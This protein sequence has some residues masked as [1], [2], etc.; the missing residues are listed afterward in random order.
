[1]SQFQMVFGVGPS[2]VYL[3]NPLENVSETLLS[4]QLC[5]ESE[6]LVRRA[7]VLY[8]FDPATCDLAEIADLDDER[9]D[10][11]N[12]LGQVSLSIRF[13]QATVPNLCWISLVLSPQMLSLNFLR[14]NQNRMCSK[15]G[16]LQAILFTR[17]KTWI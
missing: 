7:D 12:V 13:S 8:R 1:M 2:G 14:Q 17:V 15:D 5:S 4:E 3:T 11:Y 9:W 10:E 6:L 16:M